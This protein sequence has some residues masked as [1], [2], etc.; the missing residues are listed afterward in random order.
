[1]SVKKLTNSIY[2]KGSLLRFYL[3]NFWAISLVLRKKRSYSDFKEDLIVEKYVPKKYSYV[4]IGAGHPIIGNNTYYFYRKGV[5]GITVEPIRFHNKLHRFIRSKDV[6]IE[7]L[8]G[9]TKHLQKFYEFNP[10][11]YSTC[12][13]E[14]YAELI[15]AGMKARKEY[16]V[17]SVDINE[18]FDKLKGVPLF[19]S[20]DCEG[21]DYEI[22]KMIN[23]S[24][25]KN[26]FAIIFEKSS[27]K[28]IDEGMQKIMTISGFEI[29]SQT[30]NNYI[31]MKRN[32]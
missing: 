21:F 23:F 16:Y 19:V 4:D 5:T 15:S 12:S 32:F 8:I 13:S 26:I 22:L 31:F 9:N 10:T 14:K 7:A 1:M 18:V 20:I 28:S 29:I 11:Q 3:S 27:N 25:F 6:Q 24:K 2:K 17:P 30:V